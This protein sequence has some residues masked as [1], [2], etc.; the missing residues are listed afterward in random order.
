MVMGGF[1]GLE[2]RAAGRDRLRRLLRE[3]AVPRV[4]LHRPAARRHHGRADGDRRPRRAAQGL[5]AEGQLRAGRRARC[6]RARRSSTASAARC[7]HG[8]R[9]YCSSRSCWSGAMAA[10]KRV[11]R[12]PRTSCSAGPGCTTRSRACAPVVAA[13]GAVRGDLHTFNWLAA[14]GTACALATMASALVLRVSV[15]MYLGI[16]GRVAE[17][18]GVLAAH[19]RLRARPRLRHELQRRRRDARPRV[20]GDGRAVPVL[21]RAASAGSAC[22]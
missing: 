10:S 16:L 17:A 6:G 22:S 5:A 14:A 1:R 4:E 11:A 21:Q 20:R 18:D 19:D 7:S 3:R 13:A 8:R 12:E 15:G 2:G 9:I